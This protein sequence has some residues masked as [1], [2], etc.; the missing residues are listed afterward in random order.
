MMYDMYSC[1][2][3]GVLT[4]QRYFANVD[5]YRDGADLLIEKQ[6]PD[7]HW[8]DFHVSVQRKDYPQVVSH[9]FAILFLKRCAPPLSQEP[10]EDRKVYTGEKR[11]KP[12]KEEK[13][14][15]GDPAPPQPG[16]K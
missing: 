11:E 16:E 12:A 9:C 14:A 1:E 8:P 6:D 10:P 3:A 13:P 4:G 7:G 2:R 5:W 15:Q